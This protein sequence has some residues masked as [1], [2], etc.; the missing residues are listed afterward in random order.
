MSYWNVGKHSG[1]CEKGATTNGCGKRETKWNVCY[2]IYMLILEC[3]NIT[4]SKNS[5]QAPMYMYHEFT[6]IY[7]LIHMICLDLGN[8]YTWGFCSNII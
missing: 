8:Y 3:L 5:E 4:F 6:G 2:L 7:I 1:I